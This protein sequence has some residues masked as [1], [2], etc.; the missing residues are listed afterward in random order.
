V[1]KR[2]W[3]VRVLTALAVFLSFLAVARPTK[4]SMDT[5]FFFDEDYNNDLVVVEIS[6]EFDLIDTT[7]DL[8][9]ISGNLNGYGGI[10]IIDTNTQS[11]SICLD[12]FYV[13]FNKSNTPGQTNS[14]II[15]FTI[16]GDVEFYVS[17]GMV[18]P[19][20]DAPFYFWVDD[21]QQADYI[22]PQAV[23]LE[24]SI[25]NQFGGLVYVQNAQVI[26]PS[27]PDDS[28]V[29][30][31]PNVYNEYQRGYTIGHSEG[32]DEALGLDYNLGKMIFA[33]VDAPFNVIR[34]A[35]DFEFF[36]VNFKVLATTLIS[37]GLVAFV[38]KKVLP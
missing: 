16:Y 7:Y 37:I 30:V 23:F 24:E 26:G 35:L 21:G 15:W 19:T 20:Y 14:K 34:K 36:G 31:A 4:A 38:L 18:T 10:H 12:N 25:Y 32:Y 29:G 9:P 17:S 13:I 5:Q 6:D 8:Q 22:V 33:V 2:L 27:I 28:V 1:R 3:T 11:H